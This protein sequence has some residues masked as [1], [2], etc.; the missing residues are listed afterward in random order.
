MRNLLK[1]VA[2][3]VIAFVLFVLFVVILLSVIRSRLPI[4]SPISPLAAQVSAPRLVR[5]A[6]DTY[7]P[8][9]SRDAGYIALT[10]PDFEG[11]SWNEQMY[12]DADGGPYYS[13]YEEINPPIG[14]TAWWWEGIDDIC[15]DK[16][17]KIGYPE[18]KPGRPEFKVF[19]D[20]M[21]P[22]RVYSGTQSSKYFTFWRCQYAGLLQ[23][24]SIYPSAVY[25]ISA[26]VQAWYSNCSTKPYDPP[27]EQDCETELDAQLKVRIGVDPT[28]GMNPSSL[29]IVWSDWV[30]P[31]GEFEE[32]TTSA[33]L[34]GP[35]TV[36]FNSHSN[37]PLKH[38]DVYIDAVRMIRE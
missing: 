5:C 36:F 33:R 31:Y 17:Y 23:E 32:I 2:I 35:A 8:I 11:D 6:N 34:M 22:R 28:G 1:S 13:N 26:Q 29:D 16:P 38:E 19:K 14:W 3:P 7:L 25:T 21:D 9:V 37:W 30:E 12:W 27:L 4:E 15:G 10:N 24:I 20:Y 18:Y